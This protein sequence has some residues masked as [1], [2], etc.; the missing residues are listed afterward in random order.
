MQRCQIDFI[1]KKNEP[2]YVAVPLFSMIFFLKNSTAFG[3]TVTPSTIFSLPLFAVPLSMG[4]GTS[5]FTRSMFMVNSFVLIIFPQPCSSSI[6]E[7]S[8]VNRIHSCCESAK[9]CFTFPMEL[10]PSA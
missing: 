2:F 6:L 5:S 1:P 10:V 9:K 7:F 8:F 3:L 4:T